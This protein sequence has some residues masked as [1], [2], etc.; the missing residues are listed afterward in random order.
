MQT[1]ASFKPEVKK[2]VQAWDGVLYE[3]EATLASY[4]SFVNTAKNTQ[5]LPQKGW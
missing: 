4:L 2:V 1:D 5:W 3:Y